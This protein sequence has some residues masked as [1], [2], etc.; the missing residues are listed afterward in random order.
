MCQFYVI[1]AKEVTKKVFLQVPQ[2]KNFNRMEYAVTLE[3]VLFLKIRNVKIQF[4]V[5]WE[6]YWTDM[7]KI[8]L[9]K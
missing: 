8:K 2:V 7:G 4:R 3:N 6:L 1:L 9:T 5:E